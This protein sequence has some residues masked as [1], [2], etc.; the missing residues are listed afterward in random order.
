M[1]VIVVEFN[2]WYSSL[3][4]LSYVKNSRYEMLHGTCNN[5]QKLFCFISVVMLHKLRVKYQSTC[6]ILL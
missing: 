6:S 4:D 3:Q 5:S 2:Y 1:R